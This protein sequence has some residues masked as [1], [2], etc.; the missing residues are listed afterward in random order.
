MTRLLLILSLFTCSTLSFAYSVQPMVSEISPSGSNSQLMMKVE[1][2][3]TEPLEL[4]I[5]PYHLQFN[6]NQTEELV[7]AYDDILVIPPTVTVQPG[8]FQSIL[9][10]YIGDPSI[11][12]SKSYR[13][14]FDQAEVQNN[15][16]KGQS[17]IKM[18][19]QFLTLLNVKPANSSPD[20]KH[21]RTYTDNGKWFLELTNNGTSYARL[22]RMEWKVGSPGSLL[23]I[24]ANDIRSHVSGNLL[25]PQ[26][27]RSFEFIPFDGIEPQ[28]MAVQITES[29]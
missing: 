24:S 6:E 27:T 5:D 17:S 29:K 19:Y 11:L 7:E 16:D 23:A 25:L 8:Q 9:V 12:T 3:S 22:S 2:T 4:Q 28:A 14:V 10:R 21:E 13:V 20:I 18:K 1:N 15:A 26:Q